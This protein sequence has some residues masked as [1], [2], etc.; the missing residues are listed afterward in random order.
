MLHYSYPRNSAANSNSFNTIGY[1]HEIKQD[2]ILCCTKRKSVP[3]VPIRTPV[4]RL[5]PFVK[6]LQEFIP[7]GSFRLK[8]GLGTTDCFQLVT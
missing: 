6:I 3:F 7:D 5:F 8:E 1:L 4:Q 2:E